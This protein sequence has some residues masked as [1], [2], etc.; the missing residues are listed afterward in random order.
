MMADRYRRLTFT[1]RD[2]LDAKIPMIHDMLFT[3][4]WLDSPAEGD[5]Q[6]RTNRQIQ[7]E[8]SV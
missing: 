3:Q 5:P 1:A 2:E 6:G 4:E 7:F 8:V